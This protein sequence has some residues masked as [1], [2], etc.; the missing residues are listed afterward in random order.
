MST[1]LSELGNKSTHL[2]R[3]VWTLFVPLGGIFHIDAFVKCR[4]CHHKFS[5]VCF[6]L[7]FQSSVSDWLRRN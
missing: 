2:W 7:I 6:K 4:K 1:G 5:F 3:R